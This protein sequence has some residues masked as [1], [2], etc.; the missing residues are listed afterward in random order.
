MTKLMVTKLITVVTNH[1]DLSPINSHDLSIKSL[2]KL[3]SLYLHLQ[4][5]HGDQTRQGAKLE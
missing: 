1:K 5:T 2:K 4:N 3:S